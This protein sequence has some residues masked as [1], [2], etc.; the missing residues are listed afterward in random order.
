M[1]KSREGYTVE[2]LMKEISTDFKSILQSHGVWKKYCEAKGYYMRTKKLKAKEAKRA[3]LC[4]FYEHLE[5]ED[6]RPESEPQGA[7]AG[8]DRNDLALTVKGNRKVSTREV[9][10][11]VFENMHCDDVTREMAP[12]NGAWGLL[13]RCRKDPDA[14][15]DF[16]KQYAKLLPTR[17][18]IE[19]GDRFE[20]DGR[21]QLAIID[22]VYAAAEKARLS[23][24]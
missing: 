13:H 2:K 15:R 14:M 23:V 21:E 10:E 4:E 1:A 5:M 20:D 9:F 11:W 19:A 3:A 18:E 22:K 12:S 24:L 8:N 7:I 6:K 17:A 16:D